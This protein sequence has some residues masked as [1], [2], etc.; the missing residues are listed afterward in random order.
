[1]VCLHPRTR[2]PVVV[3][4]TLGLL[5]TPAGALA[6]TAN[7]HQGGLQVQ[8]NNGFTAACGP[9]AD[10]QAMTMAVG[11]VGLGNVALFTGPG[12]TGTGCDVI[13]GNGLPIGTD[14]QIKGLTAAN[15]ENNTDEQVAVYSDQTDDRAAIVPAGADSDFTPVD[16]NFAAY[17][18][19]SNPPPDDR[20]L[21]AAAV[22]TFPKS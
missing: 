6:D 17:P 9:A 4:V 11:L 18:D 21:N 10:I 5:A 2:R 3:F 20:G 13:T 22:F 12:R 1:M 14:I 15:A 16:V 8:Q 7:H 19:G